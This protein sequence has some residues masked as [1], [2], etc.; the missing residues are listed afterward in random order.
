MLNYIKGN[1]DSTF[2][3]DMMHRFGSDLSTWK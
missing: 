2:A 1:Q 3:Q